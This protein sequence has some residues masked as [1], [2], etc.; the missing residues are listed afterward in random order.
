MDTIYAQVDNAT[1]PG[2]IEKLW[3][4]GLEFVGG[5]GE[6]VI[7]ETPRLTSPAQGA[8]IDFNGQ[9]STTLIVKGKYLTQALALS[10]IGVTVT[11]NGNSV[12]QIAAADA[13]NG[14]TLTL[15]KGGNFTSGTLSFSSS[16]IGTRTIS[17][18]DSSI[19]EGG[20]IANTAWATKADHQSPVSATGY[21]ITPFIQASV[22]GGKIN[23]TIKAGFTTASS[24]FEWIGSVYQAQQNSSTT[25]TGYGQASDPKTNSVAQGDGTWV[26]ATFLMSVLSTCYIYD[27]NRGAYLWAGTDVNQTV[28][29][30]GTPLQTSNT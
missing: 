11:V 5:G 24:G 2:E 27:N 23:V 9:S 18:E 21:C 3:I 22:S 1:D 6:V 28:A 19:L 14:V 25:G 16:E 7:D 12:S 17:V 10:A 26:S 8:S 30:D 13:N 20:C 4:A 15:A 29:P